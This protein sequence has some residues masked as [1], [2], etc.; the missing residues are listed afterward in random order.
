MLSLI[1]LGLNDEK[2]ITLRGLE[3]AKQADKVYIE[4]YTNKWFGSMG[5]LKELIGKDVNELLR[6]NLEDEIGRAHV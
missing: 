6:N 1:G 5:N 2:D 3:V 4:L